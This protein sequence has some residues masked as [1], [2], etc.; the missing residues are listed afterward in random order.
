V[1]VPA[2]RVEI[3]AQA[4]HYSHAVPGTGTILTRPGRAWT[5]LFRVVPGLAHRVSA[6]WPS[7]PDPRARTQPR[8]RKTVSASPDPRARTPPRPRKTVSASPDPRARTQPRLRKTV[9]ASPDPRA[10]TPSQPRKTV[11]ASLDPRARTQPRLRK[12]VSASS[13]PRAR[14]QPRPQRS[15]RL[16]RP[17]ARTDHIT[18]GAIITLPLASSGYGEQDRRPI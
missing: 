15:H 1:P 14:T 17:R 11:S 2:L 7:I 13:D 16:A 9:F 8:L 4:R 10:R 6:K 18:G 5:V 12:T 3:V